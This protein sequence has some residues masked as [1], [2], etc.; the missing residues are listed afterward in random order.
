MFVLGHV[1]L[2]LFKVLFDDSLREFCKQFEC[3]TVKWC[4][5]FVL[6]LKKLHLQ[7]FICLKATADCITNV[8]KND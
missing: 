2:S 8:F 3:N 1:S 4:F 6:I 5:I 7:N